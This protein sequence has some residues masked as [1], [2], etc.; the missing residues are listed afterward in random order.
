M[1]Q[2]AH[3]HSIVT[4]TCIEIITAQCLLLHLEAN[5]EHAPSIG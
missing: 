1:L 3:A 5:S 2:I 4:R